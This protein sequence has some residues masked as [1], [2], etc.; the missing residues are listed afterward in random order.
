MSS[1]TFPIRPTPGCLVLYKIRPAI[2]TAVAD[3]ID[4]QLD[5]AKTKRVRPKDLQPL[6]PGPLSALA[7]LTDLG[8]DVEEAWEL[9]SG[10]E[11]DL[12]ELSEL[13]FGEYTPAS[14]WAAW[15][16]VEDG[17]YFEGSPDSIRART[18]EQIQVDREERES[19]QA[20]ERAWMDFLQRLQQGRMEEGDRGQ[21]VEVE[22][23]ALK[24]SEQSRI[25]KALGLQEKMENAHRLLT[26]IGYWQQDYNPYPRR[27]SLPVVDPVLPLPDSCSAERLDLTHLP[28]FAIDDEGS[29]DPDDAISVD[30]DL[31]WVHIA[32]ASAL[33]TPDSELDLEARSRAANLYLPEG[34]VHML[35]QPVTHK[36]GLGL[37]EVS[38]A[39]SVG[40]VLTPE[41]EIVDTR[42]AL[43]NIR[44]SR[45]SYA[46]IDQRLSEQPF[47]KLVEM[48]GSYRQRRLASGAR[49][50][51]L[52][53]VSVRVM[54]GAVVIR[55]LD[56]MGSRDMVTDAML[57]A[58]EAVARYCLQHTIPIPFAT[59][60]PPDSD[61]QPEGLAA[62]YAFRRKFKPSR[63]KTLE[64][65]HAGL[66]LELYC[67]VTSPLRRYMD[68]VVHQQLRSHLMEG[69]LLSDKQIS[70]R[71]AIADG[72]SGSVRKAE[73]IS[74]NH[75]KLVFLRQNPGWQGM[76]KVVEMKSGRATLLIPELALETKIRIGHELELDSELALEVQEVDIP[77]L[78]ARFRMIKA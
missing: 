30:G 39:L 18:A 56:R 60:P 17:L 28:A 48:A 21:L 16:L 75:W 74:N 24:Q 62:M 5:G 7:D 6:H 19:K 42:V 32:D 63:N 43:T 3:K 69:E 29:E 14:A 45:H 71:I 47:A 4:I 41:A 37:Q 51:D 73:R 31:I 8:G 15:Q 13:A 72:V 40:F 52:P 46:D 12:A 55:P 65:P 26:R 25:L 59:Q 49:Q 2:V 20:A 11:T 76:G 33:I 77:N 57:M 27:Q 54:D 44:A 23:L 1:Q 78:L 53:E 34:T 66:G 35:P 10:T 64:E 9:V 50:L 58:G 68:L 67:R 38:P 36:L 22:K 70:E 61:L